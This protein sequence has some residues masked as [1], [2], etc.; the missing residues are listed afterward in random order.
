[1]LPLVQFRR[2]GLGEAALRYARALTF[3]WE[4]AKALRVQG[5]G[6]CPEKVSPFQ[7]ETQRNGTTPKGAQR[8]PQF[9]DLLA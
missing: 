8:I 3:A 6:G 5:K 4:K 9:K 1:L 7:G 2:P